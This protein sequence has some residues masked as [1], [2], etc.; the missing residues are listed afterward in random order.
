MLLELVLFAL[1]VSIV[2]FVPRLSVHFTPPPLLLPS[3]TR[4][5]LCGLVVMLLELVL[6]ALP[7]SIVAFVPKLFFG[8]VLTFISLD[9]MLDWLWAARSKARLPSPCPVHTHMHR[10]K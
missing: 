7:V 5:R 3:G 4:S 1:P 9:L 8:A 10:H 2:A 6:F